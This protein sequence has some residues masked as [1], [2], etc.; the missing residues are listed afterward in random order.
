MKVS[1]ISQNYNIQAA[2]N[3]SKLPGGHH[4]AFV[5]SKNPAGQGNSLM[6]YPVS[7]YISFEA[8][9]DKSMQA[10][11]DRNK[12]IMPSTVKRYIESLSSDKRETITPLAAQYEAFKDL[13]LA[14][15]VDDVKELYPD[16]VLFSNLKTVGQTVAKTGFLYEARLMKPDLEAEGSG[17]LQSEEDLTVYLLKKIFLE[18]KTK[19]QINDDLDCDLNPVFKNEDKKYVTYEVLS[20][21]GIRQNAAY[22]H[23]LES[24]REGYSDE[25]GKKVSEGLIGYWNSLTAEQRYERSKKALLSIE[26]WWH[27]LPHEEKLALLETKNNQLALL[28]AYANADKAKKPVLKPKN[29]EDNKDEQCGVIDGLAASVRKKRKSAKMQTSLSEDALYVEWARKNLEIFEAGLSDKDKEALNKKRI[30]G[31]IA[32]WQNLSN[33]ERTAL[34]EKMQSGSEKHRL[35]MIDAWNNC[36]EIREHM[37]DFMHQ[38][39]YHNPNGLFYRE[40]DF[41]EFQKKIMTTFW[42]KYPEDAIKLGEEIKESY[43]KLK[44]S[45]DND[46]FDNLK[47]EILDARASAKKQ[48]AGKKLHRGKNNPGLKTDAA[49]PTKDGTPETE[50][51]SAAAKRALDKFFNNK[52]CA[53]YEFLPDAFLED[54]TGFIRKNL[55][56]KKAIYLLYKIVEN[57]ERISK[58]DGV[59]L[60]NVIAKTTNKEE[61]FRCTR[62]IEQA[63]AEVLHEASNG[64]ISAARFFELNYEEISLIAKM[65]Y[66]IADDEFPVQIAENSPVVIEKRPDF[67]K[68]DKLYKKYNKPL[69]AYGVYE[70]VETQIIKNVIQI[71]NSV[72]KQMKMINVLEDFIKK[73]G[74][75]A[76]S[77]LNEDYYKR[78]ASYDKFVNL[79]RQ[80]NF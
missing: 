62:A 48:S 67:S 56:D 29:K 13:L 32:R 45:I 79:F 15:N 20:S 5:H 61:V 28:K 10:F 75:S 55:N 74:A 49:V 37:S 7:Y 26:N 50:I 46:K 24:T 44:D 80:Q 34:I 53:H 71:E 40:A 66:T 42:Q 3:A 12:N 23:S 30:Q 65:L 51:D 72:D 25:I 39:N 70:A 6:S 8:R 1:S 21:L 43:K 19:D 33:E 41:S 4:L 78:A 11:Y 76:E 36:G 47:F 14:S 27:S 38:N 63:L 64:C 60:A 35:I 17:I 57:Q 68:L 69:G 9:T 54:Y 2:Q 22:K 18:N 52:Y 31:Q 59:Y 58:D 73:Y 77:L 16:E